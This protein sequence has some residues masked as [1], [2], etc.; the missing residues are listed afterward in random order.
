MV[1]CSDTRA[2]VG[3]QYEIMG[4]RMDLGFWGQRWSTQKWFEKD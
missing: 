4:Y 2:D 1:G 3:V